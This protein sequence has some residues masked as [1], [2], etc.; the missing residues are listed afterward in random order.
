MAGSAPGSTPVVTSSKKE[1]AVTALRWRSRAS[2]RVYPP[3]A[4]SSE[5]GT[6]FPTET[7]ARMHCSVTA[8]SG[9]ATIVLIPRSVPRVADARAEEN[10]H[11][12]KRTTAIERFKNQRF[13][14]NGGKGRRCAGHFHVGVRM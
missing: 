5:C 1:S 6:L 14:E 13:A 12:G 7:D 11:D 9:T 10:A 3:L 8:P 2:A 4:P